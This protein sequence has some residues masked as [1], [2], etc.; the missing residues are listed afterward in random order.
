MG[1]LK[2]WL[3]GQG[4]TEMHAEI[5]VALGAT[6]TLLFV[7]ALAHMVTR[8][9]VERFA[10]AA[11]AR[12]KSTWDDALVDSAVFSRLAHLV[13][14]VVI[15]LMIPL[16]Y[17]D[18]PRV[19]AAVDTAVFVYISVVGMSLVGALLDAAVQISHGVAALRRIPV[20][21]ISQVL[22]IV[23][24][25]A[26][27]IA[28]VAIL[29]GKSPLIFFSGLGAFSAVLLL[30]FKDPILGFIA[31][32]QLTAF[33]MVRKGDWIEMPKYEADG[34]VIDVSLTTVKVQNWDKTITTIPT[35]ALVSQSF[36][37]WRGMSESG[38]RRIKRAVYIDVNS[39][40]FCDREM[41]ERFQRIQ[42]ITEYVER[43]IDE[44]QK[45]NTEVDADVSLLVNGRHMTN[46]GT[47]RAYLEAY[48]GHHESISKDMTFLIRQLQPT[49]NGLPIEIYVFSNDQD[50][51]RYEGIQ[52]DIFDHVL[53]IL[54]L[55]DLRA[56][57]APTGADLRAIRADS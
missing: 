6:V 46:V 17:S 10:H 49:E 14:A 25:F 26:G 35:Y 7:A 19:Q 15:H 34:D 29:F 41:L 28:I 38:G 51:V 22:K 48:L 13:P 18:F 5:A 50:W 11:A 30:V 53:A 2:A 21:I 36:R 45:F 37:N 4:L 24:Y 44:L 8:R 47:F 27:G 39:I 20:K 56:F 23:T 54:P 43:K 42:F 1:S 31:G 40:R 52:S 3:A 33:N 55:F 57:Q 32:I 9:I 12:T 16:A